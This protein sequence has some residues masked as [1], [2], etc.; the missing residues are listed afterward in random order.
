MFP[1]KNQGTDFHYLPRE[2]FGWTNA[3]Y[4]V[5][6]TVLNQFQK[7]ALGHLSPPETVFAKR[8]AA[9]QSVASDRTERSF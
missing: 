7:R 4:Q 2:G 1:S 3:S 8:P 6:L 5:G 9:L